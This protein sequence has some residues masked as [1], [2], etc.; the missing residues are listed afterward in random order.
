MP[1]FA[2]RSPYTVVVGACIAAILG[3]TALARMPVDVFPNLKIPAVVVAT[4]YP[5]MPPLDMERDI[6][7]RYERFFTLGSGIEHIE[8]RSLPGVSMITV[9]LHAGVDVDAAAAQ[10]ATLAMADLGVLPPG[11]LPPL[12]LKFDASSL[13]VTLVTVEGQ[14]YSQAEIEDQA[15]YNIRNQLATVSGASVPM[16]FGGKIRQIMAYVDRQAL[17]ARNLTLN[18]VVDALND[19]NLILPAGDAKIGNT[20]YY[21]YSNALVDK[22]QS[23]DELPVKLGSGQAPVRLGDVGQ[24]KDATAIQY[25]VVLIDGQP[26]VYIPVLKQ[27]G[28]NTIAVVS[29][30]RDLLPKIIGMPPGMKLKAIF[31]QSGYILDAVHSLE[32]E[33]VSGSILA[34]LMI[35]IFLGSFR[36]TLGIFLSIPLSILAAAFALFMNDSTINVMTLGGF[37]LAIGRL[38]DDSVVVLEN[39]NRHLEEGKSPTQAAQD[40][41]EEVALPVLASTITTIIVFFPVMFLFGVAK[42]LFSA[43]A[44]AVVLAMLASYVVA[45]AVIPIYCARFLVSEKAEPGRR[46][47]F[48]RLFDGFNRRY[49]RFADRYE[50]LLARAL[51]RKALVIAGVAVIF[52]GSLGIYPLLGTQLFPTTDAGKFIIHMRSPAGTRIEVTEDLARRVEKVIREV[53][54]PGEIGTVVENLGLAPSIS[55]IYSSNSGEDTGEIMVTLQPDHKVSTFHYMR[56][57]ERQ[58]AREVPE[59]TA[60]F[61]SGSIIDAVLNF[62]LPA[63]IDIQVSGPDYQPLFTVAHRLATAISGLP[64]VAQAYIPQEAD[65]P[66]LDVKVDR[67][68]AARL[69]LTEKDVVTNVITALT[70]NQMIRPSIW[71]DRST[72]NDYFLTAQY[73]EQ[74]IDSIDTLK[75]IPVHH[76]T[77]GNVPEQSILLRNVARIEQAKFPSEADHYNIQRV[78]DVLVDPATSDL[79]GTQAAIQRRLEQIKLPPDVR[80][81][82]RGAVAAMERSFSSFGLGLGMAVVLLYLVMVAQFAS[83]VD[84]FI[85]MF[86]VPMGLIGV[87]WTLWLT[88]TTLNIE[89]FMGIIV[90]VGIVVSNSILLVDFANQRRRE[91]LEL[92]RAVVESARV[93]MRPILMTALA[94]VAGLMPI[95]L[96]LGA[97]SEASAPLARAAVGGLVVSTAFT[98]FLVPCVYE[99]VYAGRRRRTPAG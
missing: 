41:A 90:M 98:L 53:I 94:T 16:P 50:R 21:I 92:R 95:A 81:H 30:I 87:I 69:G 79:G 43:L 34:S 28:A 2:L 27:G 25:N 55:A 47:L 80:V 5:G 32:H 83:F 97:G 99:L 42:Y 13:P 59:A 19:T 68:R 91:G 76:L 60:F 86:A 46:G 10:L 37:A 85:I 93:R 71:I 96:E 73:R 77:K 38:V 67:V 22:P 6:T 40:G 14:G 54:P 61:S 84:P 52:V 65:Y 58:L 39:I 64:D 24:V 88:S 72:G 49:E 3:L 36:S 78:V 8:S 9:Y 57:L 66:T 33:A 4:F 75:D 12:V 89:S 29:G 11:T 23:L 35:L 82:Y 74:A 26:S 7:T 62:G 45:M 48:T 70:S 63:P 1:S 20:D 18:S 44:L 17:Q 15:R 56:I 51:D 31:D